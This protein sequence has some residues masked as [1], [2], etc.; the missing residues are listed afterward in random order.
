MDHSLPQLLLKISGGDENALGILIREYSDKMYRFARSLTKNSD[1][2]EEI[3]FDV[4]MNL[5][6]LKDKLPPAEHFVHYLYK[7]VKNT[8]LNY[9]KKRTLQEGDQAGT[10]YIL[11]AAIDKSLTPEEMV[12]SKENLMAI[13]QTINSLPVRCRQIFMLVKEDGLSYSEVGDLLDISPATVNVQITIALK[14][15]WQ[16]LKLAHHG[17]LS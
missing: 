8:S 11:E 16:E 1:D 13:N 12:I 5:W 4:F 3:V 7:A 6:K 10:E 9:L 15:I 14:K 17:F 2:A